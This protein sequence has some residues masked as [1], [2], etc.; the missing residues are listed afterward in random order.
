MKPGRF[1]PGSG[2]VIGSARKDPEEKSIFLIKFFNEKT[3]VPKSGSIGFTY[4]SVA[5]ID[6][7]Q[8]FF[9][10]VITM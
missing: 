1:G 2:A 10:S 7:F 9:L 3:S 4:K 8:G 6:F 5:T